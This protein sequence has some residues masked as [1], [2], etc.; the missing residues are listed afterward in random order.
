VYGLYELYQSKSL[1]QAY[2]YSNME[3]D[4]AYCAESFTACLGK[5]GVLTTPQCD[6]T[7]SEENSQNT[8]VG[9]CFQYLQEEAR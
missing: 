6:S 8:D 5:G 2:Q 1:G 9:G 4:E 7:T 3:S